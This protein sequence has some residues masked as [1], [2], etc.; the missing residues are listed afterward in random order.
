MSQRGLVI[1]QGALGD[2]VL[3]FPALVS[4]QRQQ[5]VRLTLLCAR[6]TGRMAQ[7][8]GLVDCY[9]STESRQASYLFQRHWRSEASRF[10]GDFDLIIFIGYSQTVVAGLRN[11][12]GGSIYWVPPRPD[13][14]DPCHVAR[15]VMKGFEKEGLLS[16]SRGTAGVASS[17]V[18]PRLSAP[19]VDFGRKGELCVLHVGSGSDRKRWNTERFVTVPREIQVNG[20]GSAVFLIGP[21]EEGLI[22]FVKKE[23]GKYGRLMVLNPD[24]S[25]GRAGQ[26]GMDR[27]NT[28]FYLPTR[29]LREVISLLK[30][31]RCFVGNDSGL[32]HLAAYLGV[33]TIALFGPS[34]P[35]RWAPEGDHV[36]VLRGAVNCEPCFETSSRNCDDPRCL[37][38]ISTE[39]VLAAL[40][41]ELSLPA[42]DSVRASSRFS[43]DR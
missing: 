16:V 1:H 32:T 8:L 24:R 41:G 18:V 22:T 2:V 25:P 34:S 36:T 21:A 9:C 14:T 23:I 43:V 39:M 20:M 10:F 11:N 42:M 31:T 35:S 29:D 7:D 12:F 27:A 13:I 38:G 4:F 28:C 15:H 17:H 3:S 26:T 30:R 6:Q 19:A 37:T 40:E 5:D 33:P